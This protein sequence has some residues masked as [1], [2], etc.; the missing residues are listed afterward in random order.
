MSPGGP[1]ELK[2][3]GNGRVRRF[4]S[5]LPKEA[6]EDTPAIRRKAPRNVSLMFIRFSVRRRPAGRKSANVGTA[7]LNRPS[8]AA[9]LSSCGAARLARELPDHIAPSKKA[10]PRRSSVKLLLFAT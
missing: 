5:A 7:A 2:M 10:P 4:F 6:A 9:R 8:S 3:E 1:Y